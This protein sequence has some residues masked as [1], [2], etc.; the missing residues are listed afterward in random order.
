MNHDKGCDCKEREAYRSKG[1]SVKL[2]KDACSKIAAEFLKGFNRELLK[3][4]N[5]RR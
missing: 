4:R 3:Q 5:K 2:D 1:T